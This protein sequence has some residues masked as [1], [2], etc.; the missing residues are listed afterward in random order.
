MRI[1]L[2]QTGA[3][4]D[5]FIAAPIAQHLVEQGHEVY[6]PI[7]SAYLGFARPAL[8]EINFLEI[9]RAATGFRSFEYFVQ[10]PLQQLKSLGCDNIIPLYSAL[11]D[12]GEGIVNPTYA[13]SLKFDE[14]KYAVSGVPFQRKWTLKIQRN[15]HRERALFD[16]L[17]I[18]GKPYVLRN[19]TAGCGTRFNIEVDEALL[20]DRTLIDMTAVTESPLDW[21]G[22]A[23][24]ADG[25]F[26]IDGLLSNLVDQLGIGQN[27][28][29]RLRSSV[30][31]T[32]VFASGWTF[33]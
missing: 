11:G 1:G 18:E 15:H 14:Y 33:I 10:S 16:R 29:L 21:L 20:G 31:S 27:R 4:G 2:I 30:A 3:I 26:L 8:P 5:I 28:H 19:E 9:G 7:D 25:L 32:P 6:W 22:V 17:N 13:A 12:R 24:R 23:E